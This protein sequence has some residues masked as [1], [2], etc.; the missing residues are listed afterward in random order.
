MDTAQ[1][2]TAQ[3]VRDYE[4][5]K[6][7]DVGHNPQHYHAQQGIPRGHSQ[8]PGACRIWYPGTPPGHQSPPGKS[9]EPRHH[10]PWGAR[11]VRRLSVLQPPA[12]NYM[13]L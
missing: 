1:M 6:L 11:L 3:P 7:Y 9:R 12:K 5:D 4:E 10:V 2:I 8:A 13:R